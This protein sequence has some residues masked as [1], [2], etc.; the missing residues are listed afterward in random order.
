MSLPGAVW[1]GRLAQAVPDRR[2]L[3]LLV[4]AQLVIGVAIGLA[5]LAWSPTSV[6]YLLDS[7][8]GTGIVVP[9]ESEAQV[10]ADGR[11]ALLTVLAGLLFGLLAWR[12]RSNRG[13]VTLVVLAVSSLVSSLLALAAGQL[14]SDG[15]HG[16]TLNT[17][18]HPP[19]VLHATAAIFLQPLF[20][21][22]VYTVF[23]GLSGDQQLGRDPHPVEPAAQ[24][25]DGG[26]VRESGSIAPDGSITG[27]GADG[28]VAESGGADRHRA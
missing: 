27:D 8:N 19:L 2:P 11:Y 6:S 24:P 14:L 28:S 16:T 17:A 25:A 9:A 18:F 1:P 13:P 15:E 23:V 22:L 20:A 7:G 3:T 4:L 12:L 10:A 26:S 5:W 21:V